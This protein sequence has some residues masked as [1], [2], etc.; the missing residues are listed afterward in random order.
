MQSHDQIP[1]VDANGTYR[2][3]KHTLELRECIN[4]LNTLTHITT[5]DASDRF[6]VDYELTEI[7][8]ATNLRSL[9]L[10]RNHIS[11]TGIRCLSQLSNLTLLNA[12]ENNIVDY[13]NTLQ[14]HSNLIS[15]NLGKV[16]VDN[17]PLIKFTN[18]RSLKIEIVTSNFIT[19][20]F[21]ENLKN[22]PKPFL[23]LQQ[24]DLVCEV[25]L[26]ILADVIL[27]LTQLRSLYLRTKYPSSSQ[28]FEK[29]SCLTSLTQLSMGNL[30]DLPP[31]SS[32]PNLLYFKGYTTHSRVIDRTA[33]YKL[34]IDLDKLEAQINNKRRKLTSDFVMVIIA[35]LMSHRDSTSTFYRIPYDL[36][37][38]IFKYAASNIL[39]SEQQTERMCTLVNKNL[40][41][42]QGRNKKFWQTELVIKDNRFT[43]FNHSTT[44]PGTTVECNSTQVQGII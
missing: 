33:E 23:P 21:C 6:L 35:I 5:L 38:I 17:W 13:S 15:L 8:R 43:I 25:S 9:N 42:W 26:S 12:V 36:L 1:H 3:G 39:R 37:L 16:V 31:I 19:D 41:R 29:L 20:L 40:D 11:A 10:S 30:C 28:D 14:I 32:Y 22:Q 4:H 34:K 18:L 24:L 44:V 2:L 27:A 7:L